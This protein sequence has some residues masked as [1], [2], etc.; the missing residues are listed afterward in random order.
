VIVEVPRLDPD[1]DRLAALRHAIFDGVLDDRLEQ[2]RGKARLLELRRD[3][4]LDVQA[5][6]ET[7]LFD[8]EVQALEIDLLGERDVRAR[9]QGQARSEEG[10]ER[11]KH[12]LGAVRPACHH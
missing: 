6:G 9:I 10:R 2:E 3:V 4:D 5:V 7:R 12:G 8:V 1:D 11:Q